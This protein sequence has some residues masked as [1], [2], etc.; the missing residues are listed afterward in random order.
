MRPPSRRLLRNGP[1]QFCPLHG[2]LAVLIATRPQGSQRFHDIGTPP[3]GWDRGGGAPI[4][5]TT[6]RCETRAGAKC[7]ALHGPCPCPPSASMRMG[8]APESLTV[9]NIP[10]LRARGF[11]LVLLAT[12]VQSVRMTRV[13]P[14]LVQVCEPSPRICRFT[15][16]RRHIGSRIRPTV[17]TS[18]A[19][20]TLRIPPPLGYTNRRRQH[21]SCCAR[22]GVWSASKS[23]AGAVRG[24]DHLRLRR[25]CRA[26]RHR[27]GLRLVF[28]F[29][30]ASR[31]T[32]VS[33]ARGL[34][35]GVQGCRR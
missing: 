4:P 33:A 6:E 27:R 8:L 35:S 2:D 5:A 18:V 7:P 26:E 15:A 16:V 1:H 28:V 9:A 32:H 30:V 25:R 3:D 31:R 12:A 21:L 10:S 13:A 22:E 20:C 11:A 19:P 23:I 17:A 29:H 24:A 14:T 34:R